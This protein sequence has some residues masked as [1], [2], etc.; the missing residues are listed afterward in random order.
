MS[1][2]N[3]RSNSIDGQWIRDN[4]T[5]VFN[6]NIESI[7]SPSIVSKVFENNNKK[8]GYIYIESFTATLGTQVEKEVNKMNDINGLIID[9]RGN[10]GGYLKAATD[11]A[12]VF[13]EQDK[14]IY[15]LESKNGKEV[16]KDKTDSKKEYPIAVLMNAGSAS[17][18]EI[19]AAALKESYGAILVGTKSYGKGLVQMTYELD[20]GSMAKYSSAKWLTPNGTCIE[21]N[22]LDPD[23]EVT[24]SNNDGYNDTQ[25]NKA[26]E[27]LSEM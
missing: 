10:N 23:Y 5:K 4:E 9:V 12:S 11:V 13:L 7:I 24:V 25:L 14:V 2:E 19:L 8:I 3:S 22:G 1:I 15:S 27:L 21:G 16:F 20:D 26:I 17:A 6:I 18:S